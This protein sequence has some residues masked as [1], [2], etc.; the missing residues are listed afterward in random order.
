MRPRST[1]L[2]LLLLGALLVLQASPLRAQDGGIELFAGETL[3]EGGTRVFVSHLFERKSRTFHGTDSVPDPLDR[4]F[5]ENRVVTGVDHGLTPEITLSLLAPVVWKEL[6]VGTGSGRETFRASGLGDIAVASKFRLYKSDWK[7]ST[8]N[9][10]VIGGLELPT[11]EASERENGVR[12]PRQVQPGS[13]SVDPF[14][15]TAANLSLDRWRFDGVVFGKLNTKGAHDYNDGEFLSAEIDAS[16]RFLFTQYPGPTAA[17][18]LGFQYR[19]E[20]RA[21][22]NGHSV[23]DSGLDELRIKGGLSLHPT[24]AT[25]VSLSIETPIWRDVQGTQLVSDFRTVISLGLRF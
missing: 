7:L 3:F 11:G 21:K 1:P 9:W 16:Y 25:D 13:G 4:V 10:S 18:K 23:I 8:F 12:L 5:E 6:R 14:L 24:P 22:D 20:G 19:R 2:L 17:V 15:A